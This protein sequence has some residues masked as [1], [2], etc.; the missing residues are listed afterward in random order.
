MLRRALGEEVEWEPGGGEAVS[1]RAPA[2]PKVLLGSVF[3]HGLVKSAG[4]CHSA[5]S[6]ARKGALSVSRV[7]SKCRTKHEAEFFSEIGGAEPSTI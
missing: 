2:P 1:M 3:A 5:F 4:F 6:Q 7:K